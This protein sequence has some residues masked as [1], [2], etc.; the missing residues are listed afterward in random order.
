MSDHATGPLAEISL[1][2]DDQVVPFHVAPLDVRGRSVQLGPM[3]DS[4]LSRHDYPPAVSKL[5]G[6]MTVLTVLLG[7]SLKFDGNFIIQTQSDGPVSLVI[8]D[9]STPGNVRAYARFDEARVQAASNDN[10]VQSRDL[11]GNGVLAMTIDQGPHMQRYQGI[12]SLDGISLEEAAHQYFRQ[13]EQIPTRVRLAVAEILVPAETGSGSVRSWRAGGILTQFLPDAPERIRQEDLPGGDVPDE[14]VPEIEPD[15]AWVEAGALMDTIADDELTDP[16]ISAERLLYRL[17]NEHGV[18][19]F[20][21]TKIEDQCSCSREKV[22]ALVKDFTDREDD[23]P[24]ENISTTCEFC[25][26]IYTLS[27]TELGE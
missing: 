6:E 25:G 23:T 3:L 19:V 17:F 14:Q 15:E 27:A 2:G 10:P 9:F 21:P 22:L 1:A 12:V 4:I 16:N 7:T 11:L 13:S 26:E 20:E 24:N 5:L 18:R 8:I